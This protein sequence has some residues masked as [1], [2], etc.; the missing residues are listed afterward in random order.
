M[1]LQISCHKFNG[2]QE[3]ESMHAYM[4]INLARLDAGKGIATTLLCHNKAVYHEACY[5][6]FAIIEKLKRTQKYIIYL[7][8]IIS[9]IKPN[10]N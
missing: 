8:I 6:K 5:L 1:W 4:S 3:I 9:A 7:M 10:E 2:V